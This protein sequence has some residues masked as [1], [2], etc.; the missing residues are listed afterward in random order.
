MLIREIRR[1]S[2]IAENRAIKRLLVE[3]YRQQLLSAAQ[4]S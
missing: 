1:N 2:I 3:N 4:R